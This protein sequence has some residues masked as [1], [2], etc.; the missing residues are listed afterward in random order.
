MTI[1][2]EQAR[3]IAQEFVRT[4]LAECPVRLESPSPFARREQ[5]RGR[6]CW[7]VVFDRIT[8]SDV[9]VSPEQV[10]VLVDEVS[11]TAAF[12]HVL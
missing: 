7:A 3:K 11:G 8:P 12:E 4:R 9:V 6:P 2:Q 1:S 5:V 10:I